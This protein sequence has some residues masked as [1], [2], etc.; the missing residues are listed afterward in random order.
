MPVVLLARHGSE[1]VL[2]DLG[3][4]N[5]LTPR[6][7]VAALSCLELEC[8]HGPFACSLSRLLITVL[9]MSD[10]QGAAPIGVAL[11]DDVGDDSALCESL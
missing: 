1:V 6:N 4:S 2:V 5:S 10:Q 7:V 8:A 9:S 11:E 3:A